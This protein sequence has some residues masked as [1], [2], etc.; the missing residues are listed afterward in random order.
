MS[1]VFS[2]VQSVLDAI[3]A[4]S[5]VDQAFRRIFKAEIDQ[6]NAD[7]RAA[8]ERQYV[9]ASERRFS[10]IPPTGFGSMGEEIDPRADEWA[11]DARQ[12]RIRNEREEAD[13]YRN[14]GFGK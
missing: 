1:A 7:T 9:K 8:L 3:A 11:E 10:G 6:I 13:L 14:G 4:D 5:N 12:E 2:T